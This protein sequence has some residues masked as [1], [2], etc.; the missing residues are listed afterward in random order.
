MQARWEEMCG[1]LSDVPTSTGQVLKMPARKELTA[2]MKSELL[3]DINLNINF[4]TCATVKKKI[5]LRYYN[6]GTRSTDP[7]SNTHRM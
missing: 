2:S 5:S 6:C 4:P 1:V 7:N 3:L